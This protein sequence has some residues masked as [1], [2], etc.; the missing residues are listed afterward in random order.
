[1]LKRAC[2]I[3]FLCLLFSSAPA[4]TGTRQHYTGGYAG[5]GITYSNVYTYTDTCLGCYGSAE[6]GSGSTGF[7]VTAGYRFIPYLGLELAFADQNSPTWSQSGA[8]L[9]DPPG[10]YDVDTDIELSSLQVTVLAALPFGNAWELYLRG[11]AAFWQGQGNQSLIGDATVIREVK[12]DGTSFVLGVGGGV[13]LG[14]HWHVNLDY[15]YHSISDDLMP[16]DIANDA[17]TDVLTVR[18]LYRFKDFR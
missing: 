2:L 8:L 16:T 9:E 12:N 3:L 18:V 11:G 6:Y 4:E 15:V 14:D 13:T 1:M 5:L 17:Y 10:L 7:V